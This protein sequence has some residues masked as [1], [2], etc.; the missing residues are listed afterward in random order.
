MRSS[1][2][3]AVILAVEAG[4]LCLIVSALVWAWNRSPDFRYWLLA[5][6]TSMRD[7]LLTLRR[8]DS[9]EEVRRRM[10]EEHLDPESEYSIRRG[11]QQLVSTH[12][13]IFAQ[14]YEESDEILVY[15]TRV[16]RYGL[17]FREGRLVG[18]CSQTGQRI[19]PATEDQQ[20]SSHTN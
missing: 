5:D 17:Q 6:E 16:R 14:G 20:P 2:K 3:L 19:E 15:S 10:G 18:S 9:I 1:W 13:D 8:G 7:V 12:P 11:L 4:T